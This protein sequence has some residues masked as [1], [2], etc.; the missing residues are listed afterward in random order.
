[1]YAQ[2]TINSFNLSNGGNRDSL[3]LVDFP[4]NDQVDKSFST[5]KKVEVLINK[6][7]H[8]QYKSPNKNKNSAKNKQLTNKPSAEMIDHER[9]ASLSNNPNERILE[10]VDF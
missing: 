5:I 1:M 4:I 10:L 8:K 7:I 9:S 6:G 3:S 2:N